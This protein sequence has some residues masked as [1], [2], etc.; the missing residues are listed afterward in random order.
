MLRASLHTLGCRLSQAETSLLAD[1]LRRKGYRVVPFGD[2][3]DLFVLNTCSVTE[4]A[5]KDC[6]Y[7][8]RKTL[9]HSPHAFVAVTGCYAQTGAETLRTIPGID[10]LVGTEHKM[11]LPDLLPAPTALK[12]Q[13]DAEVVWTRRIARE[14]FTL[15]GTASTEAT[16]A[17][18]KIQDGCN[19]MC[20]FCLIPFARGHERSRALHDVLR[21]AD[22]LVAQGH[23]EL[24]L[25]GVN[26]GRYES[27]GHTLLGLVKALAAIPRLDRIRISSIEPTT[28]TDALLD[29][30][31]GDTKLCQYLHVPVQ[32]GNDRIL[33]AM[34]RPYTVADYRRLIDRAVQRMPEIGLGTDVMVG[35]P[36]EDAAAFDDT[37]LL[38]QSLPLSYWHVFSYS[39]R[40]GTAAVRLPGARSDHEI[41][42]RSRRLAEAS[43]HRMDLVRQRLL[44][45]TLRILFEHTLRDGF[46]E[47]TSE[48][49]L[50]VAVPAAQ[51]EPNL[52]ADVR[53][54]GIGRHAACGEVLHTI[55]APAQL[56]TCNPLPYDRSAHVPHHPPRSLTM[57]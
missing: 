4:A 44:G 57:V 45:R 53:I 16:R 42:Q 32:S 17:L 50:R 29:Y 33:A 14:E 28:V 20:S 56:E 12:K 2:E 38:L 10:L 21:E 54:T 11:R 7:T 9:R 25:T 39:E 8:I 5:E 27:A 26:I 30:M 19:V 34:N 47:G 46:R 41:A 18:L 37:A 13:S 55:P 22:E 24:V 6:R 36:G 23:R 49:F 48:H 52:L 40:P 35:F 15:P 43:A 3:T 51:A 1:G 31:R